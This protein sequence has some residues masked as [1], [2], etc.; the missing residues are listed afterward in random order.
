MN[1]KE[2]NSLQIQ[3]TRGD[4]WVVISMRYCIHDDWCMDK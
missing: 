2:K 3:V 4:E 1:K